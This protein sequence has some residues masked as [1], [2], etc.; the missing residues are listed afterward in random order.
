MPPVVC[1][2]FADTSFMADPG[3]T[4][5]NVYCGLGHPLGRRPV[6]AEKFLEKPEEY[7]VDGYWDD[8]EMES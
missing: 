6:T 4:H 1:T 2:G 3:E 8:Y 5:T 7:T